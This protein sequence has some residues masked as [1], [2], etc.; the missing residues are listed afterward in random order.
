[1]ETKPALL[2]TAYLPPI[3]YFLQII[4]SGKILVEKHEHFIKQ[5]YRNR[6]V[7]L[8]ANGP[9]PLVI[10]V[11]KAR[12]AKVSIIETQIYNH[13]EWQRNHWRTIFSAYNS[14]PYFEYYEDYLLPFFEKRWEFLFDYN[15]GLMMVLFEILGIEPTI[16]FTEIFEKAPAGVSDCRSSITPKTVEKV[17]MPQYTQVFSHKFGFA[18]DLSIIDLIFNLGPDSL[19]YLEKLI[20]K[21]HK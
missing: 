14:S 16:G 17:E 15:M 21:N 1:M 10:P 3:S 9:I 20:V 8:G 19:D 6:C 7:V 18:A 11:E 12:N 2:A 13:E 4:R 5:S